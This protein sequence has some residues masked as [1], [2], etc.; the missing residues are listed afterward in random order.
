MNQRTAANAIFLTLVRTVSEFLHDNQ[1][2]IFWGQTTKA[3]VAVRV[4]A[5]LLEDGPAESR[6][7]A[8][9]SVSKWA[10]PVQPRRIRIN[11]CSSSIGKRLFSSSLTRDVEQSVK[12]RPAPSG[13]VEPSPQ[14]EAKVRYGVEGWAGDIRCSSYQYA[15]DN[16]VTTDS[17]YS[18]TSGA[19]DEDLCRGQL[20][21]AACDQPHRAS[22]RTKKALAPP[23]NSSPLASASKASCTRPTTA[24]RGDRSELRH[25][26]SRKWVLQRRNRRRRLRSGLHEDFCPC[27]ERLLEDTQRSQSG[28]LSNLQASISASG[29]WTA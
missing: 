5:Q 15:A 27:R 10:Q 29:I 4:A 1:F 22:Y 24:P 14:G 2:S 16:L 7:R 23:N 11:P 13:R 9:D 18:A 25:F 20:R 21:K 3:G 6:S 12:D 26:T 8:R 28:R 17:V 19:P